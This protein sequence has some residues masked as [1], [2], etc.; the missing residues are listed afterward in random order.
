MSGS[1]ARLSTTPH[2]PASCLPLKPKGTSSASG[3]YAGLSSQQSFQGSQTMSHQAGPA[4]SLNP[5]RFFNAYQ[6]FQTYL[7]TMASEP[8]VDK[9][10]RS[11]QLEKALSLLETVSVKHRT[12]GFEQLRQHFPEAEAGLLRQLSLTP[13]RADGMWLT[14]NKAAVRKHM[15]ALSDILKNAVVTDGLT[16]LFN[17]AHTEKERERLLN[18]ARATKSTVTVFFMDLDFFKQVNSKHG[19]MVGDITIRAA[20]KCIEGCF[21][22]SDLVGRIGG[23]EF[24]VVAP[25]SPK[26][27]ASE[28][29]HK[30]VS[31]LL[32]ALPALGTQYREDSNVS[33]K[34]TSQAPRKFSLRLEDPSVKASRTKLDDLFNQ[35]DLT[36][37]V[38]ALIADFSTI[39][40]GVSNKDIFEQAETGLTT[41]AK[42]KGRNRAG[43]GVWDN[44]QNAFTF[45]SVEGPA[46]A[47]V[48]SAN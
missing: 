11:Q 16:G 45:H 29:V 34:S 38:G 42:S 47:K 14:F 22:E 25:I 7:Q 2:I 31:A 36:M 5:L 20:G 21:R 27:S 32:N 44:D 15:G 1:V 18:D 30:K 12:A 4:R 46:E 35:R 3:F 24:F 48:P 6:R 17:K 13:T 26:E 41:F 37:S 40:E 9:T 10:Q 33:E 8:P 23:E 19:H 28:A 39:P 43:I